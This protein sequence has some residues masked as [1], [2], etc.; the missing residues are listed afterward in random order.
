[1]EAESR[2]ENVVL[3]KNMMMDNVHKPIIVVKCTGNSYIIVNYMVST[4]EI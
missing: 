3:N 1:M 2:S 4:E